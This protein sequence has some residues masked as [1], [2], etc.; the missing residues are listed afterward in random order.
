[1][2]I[3]TIVGAR[4]QFIKAAVVSRAIGEFNKSLTSPRSHA[5]AIHNAQKSQSDR[6]RQSIHKDTAHLH[7]GGNDSFR[8]EDDFSSPLL[9]EVIVHT[10]Q[11]FDDNMSEVF[12][13]EMAIPKPHYNLNI[14]SLSHGAMTGRML[15]KLEEVMMKE[16]PNI[17]L[18][19]GDTNSTLAGA[20]AAVKL[21]IPVAHVEAGLRSFNI[22]MPEEVNRIV[23]DRLS[24]ILFC[25]TTAAVEN[26]EQ[27][28]FNLWSSKSSVPSIN[29]HNNQNQELQASSSRS[30][31]FASK[32][33]NTALNNAT[34]LNATL[35]KCNKCNKKRNNATLRKCN[36][37]KVGD[38][39]YDAALF[40]KKSIDNF[41]SLTNKQ[42]SATALKQLF[43]LV[44]VHRAENTDSPERLEAIVKALNKIN[45]KI[46][47]V[48]PLHPR[49]KKV[50]RNRGLELK[51]QVIDPV[52]YLDMVALLDR[53][54]LVITDSGGLQKEAFFFD[55]YCLT[56][57]DETEWVE[58]VENGVNEL[59][60]ADQK[61]ILQGVKK[62]FD[63][64][65]TN[66]PNLYGQGN[67]G[68][69]IV[70]ELVEF[71]TSPLPSSTLKLNNLHQIN[72]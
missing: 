66:K 49:T 4:P 29:S 2:K 45:Q 5:P 35:R 57:R 12:F 63:K 25:P 39:M 72:A 70:Q 26:L 58:L 30:L 21:H 32:V 19:Y 13:R 20:L 37:V 60:G 33:N 55:K 71:L 46:P 64:K 34:L 6:Q 56:L 17:V 8:P 27:E 59:V 3:L 14:N 28:G 51:C 40:Y 43:I 11:H 44:T 36:I 9:E 54:G 48:I 7:L 38:V 42:F 18:V 24:S 47:V 62:W 69:K 67:A 61:K 31:I 41:K 22:A 50:L 53:C 16:K 68:E 23:T 65:L 10:G 1:M 52:G 15:E